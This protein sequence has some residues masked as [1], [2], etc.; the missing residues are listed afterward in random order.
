MAILAVRT[1]L[2]PN[3]KIT[4]GYFASKVGKHFTLGDGND[5]ATCTHCS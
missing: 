3:G 2:P 4:W 1:I 5:S